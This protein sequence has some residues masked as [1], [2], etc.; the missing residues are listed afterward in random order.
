MEDD[1]NGVDD[2]NEEKAGGSHS[3]KANKKLN[4]LSYV[5][6]TDHFDIFKA[7]YMFPL[8]NLDICKYRGPKSGISGKKC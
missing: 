2:G 3:F 7:H 5:N 4:N 1:E 8:D 6:L